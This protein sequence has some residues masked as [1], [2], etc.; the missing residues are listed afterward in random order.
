M[1]DGKE[2]EGK[3]GQV[4]AYE[5]DVKADGTARLELNAKSPGVSGGVF[6]EVDIIGLLELAVA[7]TDNKVDDGLVALVKSAFGK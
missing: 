6:L 2:V 4:G 1:L 3:L 7:K 5:I